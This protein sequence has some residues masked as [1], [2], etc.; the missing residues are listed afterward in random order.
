MFEFFFNPITHSIGN[1]VLFSFLVYGL[2][3]TVLCYFKRT[4]WLHRVVPTNVYDEKCVGIFA[5]QSI[6]LGVVGLADSF[7][8]YPNENDIFVTLLVLYGLAAFAVLSVV[9]MWFVR[10][11]NKIQ[12]T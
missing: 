10:L 8:P 4:T 9:I 5:F 2:V 11:H 1:L 6:L 3:L 7:V 12:E